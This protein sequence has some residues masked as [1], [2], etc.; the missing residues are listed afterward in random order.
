MTTQ[1]TLG[2]DP[3]RTDEGVDV[4]EIFVKL[5]VEWRRG[6][7]FA[8]IPFVLGI[9]Y[10]YSMTPLY[11]ANALILPQSKTQSSGYAA[12]FNSRS[13]GDVYIGLLRS[14]SVLDGVIDRLHLLDLYKTRSREQARAILAGSSTFVAG[15]DTMISVSV[16][17]KN[18]STAAEI[19]N[20][21]LD[22][23]EQWQENASAH[24]A[25]VR[26]RF[27]QQQLAKESLA[28]A[29]AEQ[30]LKEVQEKTGIVDPSAQTESGLGA[31]AS[32]RSQITNLQVQLASL[33]LG[34]SE[35]NPK[36]KEMR[37]QI[38][39]L[40]AEERA[41]ESSNGGRRAGAAASAASMPELNLD[42]TRKLREVKFHEALMTS[43]SN[44]YQSA[45]L[46][47]NFGD[48]TFEIVDRAVPAEHKAWPPRRSM[49]TL[50]AAYSIFF[51][52]VMVILTLL[53]RRV[54]RDPAY[55]K[56]ASVV[57]NSFWAP[58]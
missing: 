5:L 56:H 23:L 53:W 58:R 47:A 40:E 39:A 50:D 16:R 8:V 57:R 36:V 11:E 19:A 49:V 52:L 2:P 55:L 27:F 45:R 12:L 34:A 35:E 15:A 43:L 18:A 37:S 33:L 48:A 24:D 42:Y 44:Q 1:E 9:L 3:N 31:I 4:V 10:I 38:G 17:D 13:S 21:Y 25:E 28:V 7:I 20:A 29:N 26:S 51:G 54:V 41:L 6:L 30:E 46:D 22:S 14:R 32:T